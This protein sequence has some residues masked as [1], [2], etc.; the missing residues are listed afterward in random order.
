MLNANT[1]RSTP[2]TQSTPRLHRSATDAVLAGVCGG[3]GETLGIDPSLIRLAFIIATLW[4]GM[5]VLAYIVLA[6][7]LPVD[8]QAPAPVW[9]S[10][11][12]SRAVAGLV[13]VVLGGLL[14]AG[15]MGW[16]TWLSWDLFWPG[17]LIVAGVG[18]L[19]RNPRG[20]SAAEGPPSGRHYVNCSV[21]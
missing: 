15:N 8:Q 10:S 19:V 4:G 20:R 2:D 17:V 5:G 11:E 1:Q 6:I 3:I 16:T 14:L 18:L 9:I 7:V 12:R 21:S 13:L